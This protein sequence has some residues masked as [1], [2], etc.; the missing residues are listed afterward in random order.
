M[1]ANLLFVNGQIC[2]ARIDPTARVVV[3]NPVLFKVE[4]LVGVAAENA[5]GA[6]LERVVQSSG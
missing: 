5:I 3:V 4:G 2:H 6:M 1:D